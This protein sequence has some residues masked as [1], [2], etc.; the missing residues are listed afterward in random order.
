MKSLSLKLGPLKNIAYVIFQLAGSPSLGG[1][2]GGVRRVGD[3][4][5]ETVP[6]LAGSV[7]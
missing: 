4:K 1:A 6:T 3:C 2:G 5:G 7:L